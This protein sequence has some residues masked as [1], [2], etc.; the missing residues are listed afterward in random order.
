MRTFILSSLLAIGGGT[1]LLADAF[2]F[3][4]QADEAQP[5]DP[6]VEAVEAAEK[7][8]RFAEASHRVGILDQ[9]V[10]YT[11]SSRLAQAK[12]R[13]SRDR[14]QRIEIMK[15]HVEH[16]QAL[17]KTAEA[18]AEVGIAAHGPLDVSEAEYFLAEARIML[19]EEQERAAPAP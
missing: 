5:T 8:L 7:S 12:L 9:S 2:G 3:P 19:Q 17:L 4:Q 15:E 1:L 11:W 13:L 10:I 14:A 18:R 16:A 6:R